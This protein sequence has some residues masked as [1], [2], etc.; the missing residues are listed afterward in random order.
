MYARILPLTLSL[1]LLAS[2]ALGGCSSDDKAEETAADVAVESSGL[3]DGSLDQGPA[4]PDEPD[5][6]PRLILGA[7]DFPPVRGY[8]IVPGHIHAHNVFSHDACDNKP[9]VDGETGA[10]NEE[11][12]QELRKALCDDKLSFMFMTEHTSGLFCEYEYP[13][14]LYYEPGDGDELLVRD[15]DPVANWMRCADGR[16]VLLQAGF[17]GELMTIGLERHL[18]ATSEERHA[19][20]GSITQPL[21]DELHANGALVA[22]AYAADWDPAEIVKHPWDGY[23]LYNPA[24]NLKDPATMSKALKLVGKMVKEPE[25]LPDAEVVYALLFDEGAENVSSWANII[26]KRPVFNYIGTNIHRNAFPTEMPDGDRLD[27]Y[28][29]FLHIFANYLMIPAER[30]DDYD[31]VALKQA[32][33]AGRLTNAFTFYGI[34]MGFDFRAEVGT[35]LHEMGAQL[36]L[37]PAVRL[38]A[39]T[40]RVYG[41]VPA[42]S[43]PTLT[44]RILRAIPDGWEVLASGSGQVHLDVQQPGAYRAEVRIVPNHLVPWLGEDPAAGLV[45]HTWVYSNSIYVGMEYAGTAGR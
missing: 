10:R 36:P 4:V 1:T 9:R 6:D 28:R 30:A 5:F 22:A 42:G 41:R 14:V 15:G 43:E 8:V 29:R 37:A 19:L 7:G 12:Y 35:D 31:D 33:A 23:E 38:V 44:T 40:P 20:Y 24:T 2:F 18:R 17:D 13:E 27:S 45:E 16:R 25:T 39:E 32:I 34:P 11:C 21:I 26:L 3:P